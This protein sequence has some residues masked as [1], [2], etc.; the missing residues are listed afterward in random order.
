MIDGTFWTIRSRQ[1]DFAYGKPAAPYQVFT[2]LQQPRGVTTDA[3]ISNLTVNYDAGVGDI[4][5]ATSYIDHTF[6]YNFS[7]PGLTDL[8]AGFGPWRSNN[9]ANTKAFTQEL[10]IASKPGQDWHWIAG[11]FLQDSTI[12][13]TQVQGWHNLAAYGLGPN[14]YTVDD[15]ALTSRS[16]GLFGEISADLLDG[17]LVPTLGLRDYHD[18]RSALDLR[19]GVSSGVERSFNSLNPR[20]NLAYKPAADDLYYVNIAKGFRS[21][22]LQSSGAVKAA[23]AVG[24]Q[25]EL[26][27][28]QDSLWSYEVG[29]KWN[30][31]RTLSLETALYQIDWK[32]AQLTNLLVG[33]NGVTTNVIS[34][35][36]DI[37]GRGLD[38]GLSWITPFKGLSLQFSGNLNRSELIR[39]PQAFTAKPGDQIAGTPKQTAILSATHLSKFN[40]MDLISNFSYLYRGAQSE[41]TTGLSSDAIRDIRARLTLAQPNWDIGVFADN[42]A[43]QKGIA[44]VLSYTIV[45]PI[46]PRK[47]GV[48]MRYRF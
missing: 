43:N 8:Q 7:L 17:K 27:L 45:N 21:G 6:H 13:A 32:N 3:N 39:S 9:E 35:G 20:F 48:D 12:Q 4:V 24:L 44:A 42:I 28:P 25:A 37:R 1:D 14:V 41:A 5:S 34:G 29:A 26:L 11:V 38:V 10:R 15:V 46:Q 33:A 47:V 30:L 2:D 31:A 22:A 36:S 18:K 16:Q 23:Q 19:D 40:S